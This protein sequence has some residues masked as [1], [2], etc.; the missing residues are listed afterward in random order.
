MAAADRGR[1][2]IGDRVY[3]YMVR[4]Y[5]VC[6][7][8]RWSSHRALLVGEPRRKTTYSMLQTWERSTCDVVVFCLSL[9][10]AVS[11]KRAELTM[12]WLYGMHEASLCAKRRAVF[13]G[14]ISTNFRRKYKSF[15]SLV[16]GRGGAAARELASQ[17]SKPG[18]NPGRAT[19]EF[20]HVG[21]RKAWPEEREI[22]DKTR[23][24]AA[25]S[26]LSSGSV[27]EVQEEK[28]R[29][30]SLVEIANL[31]RFPVESPLEFRTWESRRAMPLVGGFSRGS[32]A[33][34]PTQ[35]FKR[36]SILTSLHVACS[37]ETTLTL[38]NTYTY[39]ITLTPTQHRHRHQTH[40]GHLTKRRQPSAPVS[41]E[42]GGVRVQGTCVMGASPLSR[43]WPQYIVSPG[44]TLVTGSSCVRRVCTALSKHQLT[45]HHFTT[46]HWSAIKTSM[47]RH[48]KLF[49]SP[50]TSTCAGFQYAPCRYFKR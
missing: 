36:C 23:R 21:H 47:F 32:T 28:L 43:E 18:L 31:V 29:D 6:V 50:T 42:D 20:S 25:S 45:M 11:I 13:K 9:G 19:P 4:R 5:H 35:P 44:S 24:P 16:W 37:S 38:Y 27:Y 30:F 46:R 26:E 34:A 48:P 14:F 7:R 17:L 1:P 49:D 10:N 8:R 41:G 12:N 39:N 15:P 2:G 3:L 33:V 22:P 40:D